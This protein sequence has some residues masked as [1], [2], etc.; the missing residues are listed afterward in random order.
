M[1]SGKE[2]VSQLNWDMVRRT[3]SL[4]QHTLV[5]SADGPPT[6]PKKWLEQRQ[7]RVKARK[8]QEPPSRSVNEMADR[9]LGKRR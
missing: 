9:L 3:E 2:N 7:A 8:P 1:A 5:P 6:D 4:R